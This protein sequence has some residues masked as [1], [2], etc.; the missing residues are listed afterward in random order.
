MTSVRKVGILGGGQLGRMLA[1]AARPLGVRVVIV[2]PNPDCPAACV[3]DEHIVAS[4]TDEQAVAAL[5]A[6]CEV[7]T[8]EIEHVNVDALA[9]VPPGVV[10]QPPAQVIAL[11]QDKLTQKQHF[12]R[13]GVAMGEFR[14]VSSTV[15]DVVTAAAEFGGY[16][17]MLKSRRLAYDGKGNARID[18]AEDI[19]GALA[20][21]SRSGD[22][23]VE[24]WV[25][26]VRELAVIV[27]QACDGSSAVYPA[28]E[29][30]QVD[31]I[32]RVVLAPAPISGEVRA[33][34][35]RL[36]VQAVA[37]FKGAAGVFGVELFELPDGAYAHEDGCI[38]YPI[39]L[40][41]RS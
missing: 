41:L 12:R 1:I 3:A 31:S 8:V 32:C 11:I 26:F 16:P 18:S 33:T 19:P 30:V 40:L 7:I 17:V 36:A 24:K 27:A 20:K 14:E 37:A 38:I 5:A 22:L 29:T 21:L 28:V 23:F 13:A 34:A 6:K 15:A 10:V 2:D 35:E 4:F 9:K 25:P 39:A